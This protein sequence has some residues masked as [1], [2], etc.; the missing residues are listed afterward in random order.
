MAEAV[1]EKYDFPKEEEKILDIWKALDAF[2]TSLKQ[3]KGK[4]RCCFL[5]FIANKVIYTYTISY[6]ITRSDLVSQQKLQ[7]QRVT[8]PTS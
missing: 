1:P 2:K 6:T 7:A 3:S 8:R 5:M 4:T